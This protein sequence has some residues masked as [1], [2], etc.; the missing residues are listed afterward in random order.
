MYSDKVTTIACF[1]KTYRMRLMD[2]IADDLP[3]ICNAL[4][5]MLI[6]D[7]DHNH[8]YPA[9]LTL[10]DLH[11]S[12]PRPGLCYSD[13]SASAHTTSATEGMDANTTDGQPAAPSAQMQ[14][15]N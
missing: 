12:K 14:K 1:R 11:L 8:L 13:W 5:I 4:V 15:K 10:P 6:L 2:R 9:T 7:Y 3:P